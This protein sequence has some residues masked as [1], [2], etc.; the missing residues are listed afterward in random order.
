MRLPCSFDLLS[1]GLHDWETT[2]V[3]SG[4]H[5]FIS[6]SVYRQH[7]IG[8]GSQTIGDETDV[9][10][11]DDQIKCF[12]LVA[13]HAQGYDLLEQI[14]FFLGFDLEDFAAFHENCSVVVEHKIN[15]GH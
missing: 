13:L 1:E 11:I 8:D 10:A 5:N 2:T 15:I 6:Q 3:N 7:A 14:W 4:E 12:V 9:G